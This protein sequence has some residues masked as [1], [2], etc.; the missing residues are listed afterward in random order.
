MKR[1]IED[2]ENT[3]APRPN[4]NYL[5]SNVAEGGSH[6][7]DTDLSTLRVHA[8]MLHTQ[9]GVVEYKGEGWGQRSLKAQSGSFDFRA[10]KV[11]VQSGKSSLIFS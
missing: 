11:A 8:P 7:V 10:W 2:D 4:R 9:L 3:P 6:L 5:S 1:K